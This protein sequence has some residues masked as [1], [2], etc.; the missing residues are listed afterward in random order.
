MRVPH[1]CRG[2]RGRL[3]ILTLLQISILPQQ[4]S[5]L[6]LVQL[7]MLPSFLHISHFKV[8]HRK[9][10]F[11]RQPH[12]SILHHAARLRIARPHDVVNRIDILQESADAFQP[13]CKLRRNRE[14]IQTAA[15]LEVSKLCD[16]Q[17]VEHDL[18]THAPRTQR[19]GFPVVLFELDVMLAQINP[20]R[21]QRLQVQ[22]LHV[23]RRRFQNHLQLH[24]LE[25]P[26]GILPI[27]PIRRTPRRLHI[28]NLI[29][30][31]PQHA[32][33]CLGCHGPCANF[34]VIGLL[35]HASALRPKCLQSQ[36]EFL[37]RERIG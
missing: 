37:E 25:K 4:S 9:L 21:S 14:Q 19:G 3:G 23:F 17:P 20:N 6:R 26:V 8:V 16:L 29:R 10:Q 28:C 13:I 22:L 27:A 5:A 24:V 32:Q 30:L 31:G 36:D 7:K 2:V 33:K 12:V 35:Q 11:I 34:H 1:P 18:P 15:L